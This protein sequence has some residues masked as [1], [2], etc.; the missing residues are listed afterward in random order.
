[1]LIDVIRGKNDSQAE[2]SF[3]GSAWE[4]TSSKLCFAALE[5]VMEAELPGSSVPG[6]AWDGEEEVTKRGISRSS[7][8]GGE[9]AKDHFAANSVNTSFL[10]LLPMGLAQRDPSHRSSGICT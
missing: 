4:C 2:F 5:Y 1:M 6:G 9:G 10:N 7:R 8:S 3:P